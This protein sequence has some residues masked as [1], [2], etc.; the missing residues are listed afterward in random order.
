MGDIRIIDI[1]RQFSSFATVE[2]LIYTAGLILLTIWLIKTSFG[3]NALVNS[4]PRENNMPFYTPF[5][6]LFIW[7]G[8]VATIIKIKEKFLPNLQSWQSIFLENLA[9]CIGATAAIAVIVFLA[10]RHFSERLK[11]FGLN[12]KTIHRDLLAAFVNLLCVWPL[13]TTALIL[14]TFFGKLIRGQDFNLPQHEE[15]ES[16][17]KYSQLSVRVLIIVTAVVVVPVFEEMLFRGTFQTMIRSF[18]VKPWLSIIVSSLLFTIIH[19]NTTHWPAL[20]VLGVCIGYAYEK[21]GSLFRPILIHSLFN[22]SSIIFVLRD[23]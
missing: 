11:G 23:V 15:L 5:I 4:A 18:L 7:L 6:P 13:V 16:I 21:S 20:F 17:V 1:I 3:K 22:A 10:N 8:T 19:S 2:N 14:T 9:L 12:P